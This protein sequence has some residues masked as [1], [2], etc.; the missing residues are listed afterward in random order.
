MR[1]DAA[2][3]T[4]TYRLQLGRSF[5]LRHAADSVPYLRALGISHIYASPYLK[6]RPGS[7]HG[8][9]V[10]D[11]NLLNPEIGSAD[12]FE[13]LCKA[14]SASGM[15]Q[16]LDFVPN[17]MGVGYADNELWLDVL[18]WGRRSPVAD[19]FDIDWSPP[20]PALQG[21]LLLPLL[22]AHYGIVL[23]RGELEL[24]FDAEAGSFSIWYFEHRLPVHPGCYRTILDRPTPETPR[25]DD[26]TALELARAAMRLAEIAAADADDREARQAATE[27]K[28][29]LAQPAPAWSSRLQAAAAGFNGQPGQPHTFK[30]LHDLLE[31]QAYRLAYWRAAAEEI[32][33][34][35]FFDINQLAG[36]RMERPE[37]FA[38]THRLIGRLME[39][40][41]LQGLRLDHIDGL[42]DPARYL[43]WLQG[44]YVRS[45]QSAEEPARGERTEEEPGGRPF[46]ILVEKILARGERLRG[47]W[48]VAGTTG[49]EC[50]NLVNGLFV[51]ARAER[52][53]D[54]AYRRF[55]RRS[56]NFDEILYNTKIQIMETLLESELNRLAAELDALS[57]CSW[58][59]RDYTRGGLRSALKEIVACFPVYR[60]YISQ[61]GVADE[62]RR[63]IDRAIGRARKTYAGPDPAILD[64]VRAAITTE[65]ADLDPAFGRKEV[66]NFAMRFQQYTG[67][68][69]AKALEDTSFYRY[70]RLLSLNEVGGDPRQFGI[71]AAG[72]HR[73]MRE[74]LRHHPDA[75][76]PL[77]THDTKRGADMRARINVLSEIPDEW[78]RRARRWAGLNRSRR[79]LANGKAVPS[80]NDEYMIYQ[81]MVGAWPPEIAGATSPE[82][83]GLAA[84]RLRLSGMVLKA[85]REAK[86]Q[87]SWYDPQED[88]EAGTLGF[89][90][91]LL[92]SSPSND[93][94]E[95]FLPFQARIA[96]LGVLNSLCQCAIAMTMPGVPDIYQ[97]CELWDFNMVDPDNRR[98]VVFEGRQHLLSEVQQR[99]RGPVSERAG[100]LRSW[101]EDWRDGKIKLALTA[102][103]L[104][105]RRDE[106]DLF[107]HGS[108][109]PL[110]FE[111]RAARHL[112]GFMR[113]RGGKTCLL[114]TGR[115]FAR[116]VGEPPQIY[117]GGSLWTACRA[118]LPRSLSQL[119][120]VLT[121]AEIAGQDGRLH[122][123]QVLAD[124]PAAVLMA[125]A[126]V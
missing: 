94:L 120:N 35:R 119:R 87:T 97:G 125:E 18:E 25:P 66:L 46:Y 81:T 54:R 38:W 74:R 34:R 102:A 21:K 47:D 49:Y 57:E 56:M 126:G 20:Q 104:A 110:R 50:I 99:L 103:L 7:A 32:N 111:G 80:A 1:N 98:P 115:L 108:Y 72:F 29:L 69:M 23:E 67:P 45:R 15:G 70:N 95:D 53:L 37:V 41:K 55:L 113:R 36:I 64:F 117:P 91:R 73:L 8:Y 43:S 105:L 118:R 14:L 77:A 4:A 93:F 62:D 48:P 6:A 60:T 100:A 112:F 116:L 26:G 58:N 78:D 2:A 82:E 101:L 96:R 88:Y 124:L 39:E 22:G 59:T 109:E 84:F 61:A 9:D 10:T 122:I 44:L 52:A 51:E 16:I 68:V 71:S 106:A 5:T 13:Q 42:F 92:E 24:R 121:G 40:G 33:Y 75:L 83:S 19:F 107:H 11:H 28:R 79:G 12:D 90:E 63:E 76:T 3:P 65:L 27:L 31:R 86:E 17:H 30:A 85:I 114:V 89:V 123:D